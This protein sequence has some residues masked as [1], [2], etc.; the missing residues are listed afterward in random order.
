MSECP[1]HDFCLSFEC[2]R[3]FRQDTADEWIDAPVRPEE[4]VVIVGDVLER[5]TNGRLRATPHRVIKTSHSRS[6]IIRFNAVHPS[7]LIEPLP[8]F[9]SEVRCRT[10]ISLSWRVCP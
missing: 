4:F 9:V 5:F 8:A 1:L 7:T 3:R 10:P 6:S 2:Y